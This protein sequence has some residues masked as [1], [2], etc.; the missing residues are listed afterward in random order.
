MPSK[1]KWKTIETRYALI[2]KLAKLKM[3]RIYHKIFFIIKLPRA[4]LQYVY[5]ILAKDKNNT[6]NALGTVDF[7][8]YAQLA[9]MQTPYI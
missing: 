1:L 6:L 8:K 2:Q 3:L 5:N 9:I 7:T 4:H